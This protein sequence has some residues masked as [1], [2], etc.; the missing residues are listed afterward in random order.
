[1]LPGLVLAEDGDD[2]SKAVSTPP[3]V[4]VTMENCALIENG[5]KR[6]ACFDTA[7][8]AEER[9]MN[10]TPEQRQQVEQATELLAPKPQGEIGAT[11]ED[12]IAEALVSR[13]LASEQAFMSLAGNFLPYKQTYLMPYSYV[14][15]PNQRPYSPTLGFTDY[16]YDVQEHEVKFQISFKVPLLPGLFDKRS[17][18]WFGY[19]QL[20][21]WQLYN[22]DN[23]APFRETNYE[24]EF[25]YRYDTR[26]DV[27]PGRLDVVSLG[28]THQSN[29]RTEPQSRSWN[30]ITASAAYGV[31][32]WL[33]IV[34]PWYRIPESSNEDNNPDLTRYVG[35][36]DY[37]AIY[38][39]DERQS[40]SLR[41]RNN[42]R[43]HDNRTTFELGY[44][45]P[46]GK[47]TKGYVQYFNGYGE[48]LVDYNVRIH[49]IGIGIMLHD[50]L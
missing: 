15:S 29:G 1:M 9:A 11:E 13:H 3:S 25:F 31:D 16:D 28:L 42:F 26:L 6:L 49:R 30:R 37:W 18:L 21:F 10:A 19:T 41:L 48:S 36:G 43:S 38:K 40:L 12:G 14:S 44:S 33:F 47:T 32:R 20:S 46:L 8:N 50:W 22:T 5:A 24:P 35:Y 17:S 45:F 39:A 2:A 23:S 4:P 34:N 27:G 7:I